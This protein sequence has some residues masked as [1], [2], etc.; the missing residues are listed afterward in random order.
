[1]QVAPLPENETAR[2]KELESLDLLDT[3]PEEDYDDI[4]QI[5]AFICDTPIALISLIDEKRQFFKSNT[6]LNVRETPREYAFCAHAINTADMMFVVPDARE[7]ERFADNP[8][9]LG[10][11]NVVFYAGMPLV[12]EA[13][14]ALGTLCVIDNDPKLL[15]YHQKATL[16]KLAKQVVNCIELRRANKELEV[17][18][19]T[20]NSYAE[21]M[22]NFASIAAHDIKEPIQAIKSLMDVVSK[23][24]ASQLGA[25]G[26]ELVGMARESSERL[27]QLTDGLMA[28]SKIGRVNTESSAVDL[29]RLLNGIASVNSAVIRETGATLEYG[30]LPVI[31]TQITP[32]MTVLQNLISNAIKYRAADRLPVVTIQVSDEGAFWKFAIV[33]NGMGIEEAYQDGIFQVFKRLHT[34]DDITGN[35]LGLAM[36]KKAVDILGGEIWCESVKGTGSTFFFTVRK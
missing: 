30:S 1:M 15:S 32:L 3:L 11:P 28:Y 19:R 29:V 25:D 9:V 8:L 2:L 6:G 35:G 34:R 12:T 7:D 23:D 10:Y 24:Y 22:E 13:G 20:I 27:L 21:Q 17:S 26:T 36:C 14:N 18:T 4:T 33:D 31:T 5:A 16:K